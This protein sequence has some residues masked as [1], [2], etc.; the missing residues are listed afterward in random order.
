MSKDSTP[1]V[2]NFAY[3]FK[4]HTKIEDYNKL[5]AKTS[6]GNYLF[7]KYGFFHGGIHFNKANLF[8]T[9]AQK[10]G[11]KAI[12][13]GQIVA[14]RL[15]DEY[16]K[17]S[18]GELYSSNFFLLKHKIEYPKGNI[19]TLFSLYMH[20]ANKDSYFTDEIIVNNSRMRSGYKIQKDNVLKELTVGTKLILNP[21]VKESKN[22][23]EVFYVDE[24][25]IDLSKNPT[26]YIRSVNTTTSKTSN[27]QS[28]LNSTPK[29][30]KNIGKVLS[31]ADG[32]N[33]VIP[34]EPIKVNAGDIIALPGEYNL[35]K[36]REAQ[37]QNKMLH[38]E[39]FT[40][41]DILAFKKEATN[42]YK[43]DKN[44]PSPSKIKI[45][46]DTSIYKIE[47]RSIVST[48]LTRHSNIRL[49]FSDDGSKYG[50]KTTLEGTHV[51]VDINK[52]ET[53]KSGKK[54]YKVLEL[55]KSTNA[56]LTKHWTIHELA[57]DKSIFNTKYIKNTDNT[58]TKE[59]IVSASN[60][61]TSKLKDKD[62]KEEKYLKVDNNYF[63]YSD[64]EELHALTFHW[65]NIIDKESKDNYSVFE[66]FEDVL[67]ANKVDFKAKAND[68]F[69]E[70]LN[71]IDKNSDGLISHK[72]LHDATTNEKAKEIYSSIIIKHSNEWHKDINAPSELL[73]LINNIEN[74]DPKE[75]EE[76]ET[77]LN[78]EKTRVENLGF[79]NDCSLIEGFPKDDKVWFINPIRMIEEFGKRHYPFEKPNRVVHSV[80]LHCS[81]SDNS[82]HDSVDIMDSWHKKRGWS[83]V[84]YHYFIK[85][86]GVIQKVEI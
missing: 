44:K 21:N 15:N 67:K 69:K 30:H 65:A 36:P 12:A 58:L 52:F 35:S 40:A 79:F 60:F 31:Q 26:L 86:D 14:F 59:L 68:I 77:N 63:L 7:T 25:D 78:G 11:I 84:G 64:I 18:R 70:I 43:D 5:L 66:K 53:V 10:D 41:D 2:P 47:Q 4:N 8:A 6:E 57:L 19:L 3:P 81:A 73:K 75:K 83:G 9:N 29:Y 42:K 33:V 24:E 50:N 37:T 16:Q 27:G 49:G 74:L 55:G 72:E 62:N 39:L 28:N 82:K 13:D 34:K 45:N 46:K 1:T 48:T 85:K 71:F 23:K 80:F 61:S 54:R 20:T 17:D 51:K 22:R 56:H 76:I 32:K 38:L